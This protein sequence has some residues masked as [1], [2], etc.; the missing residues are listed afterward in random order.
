[1]PDGREWP[2][3]VRNLDGTV[4][5]ES[6][7]IQDQG[8]SSSASFSQTFTLAS[9]P[10]SHVIDP[11]LGC[12]LKHPLAVTV[13]APTATAAEALSTALLVWAAAGEA[14]PLLP[15]GIFAYQMR[16]EGELSPLGR[17]SSHATLCSVRL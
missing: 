2:I 17:T 1:M 5:D 16:G 8:M 7:A 11:R 15:S 9:Q 6:I 14:V 12:P 3:L 4:S 13:V 10:L